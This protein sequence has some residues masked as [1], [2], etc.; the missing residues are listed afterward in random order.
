MKS[1]LG[2]ILFLGGF[3]FLLS[4]FMPWWN[5]LP[6]A[7]LSGFLFQKKALTSFWICFLTVFILWMLMIINIDINNEGILANQLATMFGLPS[8]WLVFLISG[9]FGGVVASFAGAAG[10]HLKGF[11][12]KDHQKQGSQDE[13][14]HIDELKDLRPEW[15]DKQHL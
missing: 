1:S 2:Q 3:H 5:V 4:M 15:R 12:Q 11:I 14:I 10:S 6:V 13:N 7:L 8:K 9:F